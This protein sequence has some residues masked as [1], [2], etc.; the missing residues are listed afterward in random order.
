LVTLITA[1][2]GGTI[3]W[4]VP[5]TELLSFTIVFGIISGGIGSLVIGVAQ[6]WLVI[7]S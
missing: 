7:P 3:G 6:W 5:S 4:Y 1:I 2:G